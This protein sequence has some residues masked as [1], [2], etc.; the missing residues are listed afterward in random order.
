MKKIHQTCDEYCNYKDTDLHNIPYSKYTNFESFDKFQ[1]L[2]LY[3][4]NGIGKYTQALKILKSYSPSKL[5]YE[6]KCTFEYNKESYNFKISDI[7]LEVDLEMI[8]CQGKLLWHEIYSRYVDILISKQLKQGIILCKNFQGI[9][10]ELHEIFYTYMNNNDVNKKFQMKF[11]LIT[12]SVSFINNNI[13]MN[14]SILSL[15]RPSK[16]KYQ[17]LTPKKLDTNKICNLKNIKLNLFDDDAYVKLCDVLV[18]YLNDFD[19]FDIIT[20]RDNIYNLLIYNLDIY[21]CIWYINKRLSVNNNYMVNVN[22]IMMTTIS[23]FRL[24]N[25]NYRPIYHLEN[26][27]IYLLNTIHEIK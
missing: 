16:T 27:F 17:K 11:I 4:P 14:S 12:N 3:G 6:R 22:D 18:D 10:S 9:H 23:F 2:I 21:N 1:N 26:Y 15:S 19:Q 8:G 20:L 24:Y 5:K 13:I 25:N 7:H